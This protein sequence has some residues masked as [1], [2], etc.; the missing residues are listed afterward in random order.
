MRAFNSRRG[1]YSEKRRPPWLFLLIFAAALLTV[2]VIIGNLLPL[3]LNEAAYEALRQGTEEEEPP[4]I[5][6]TVKRLHAYA[7]T[8]GADL[9]DVWE[10]PHASVTLNAP[11]TRLS[12]TSAVASYLGYE[13]Y[14]STNLNDSMEELDEAASYISGIFYPYAPYLESEDLRDAEAARETALMREFLRAGGDEIL[15]R[16]LPFS[17]DGIELSDILNYVENVSTALGNTPV[18]VA[19]PLSV[20]GEK[21]SHRLLVRLSEVA[22]RLCLDLGAADGSLTPEGWLSECDYYLSQYQMRL[23]LSQSQTDLIAAAD[24]LN[25]VQTFT[26]IPDAQL[27]IP[28][29]K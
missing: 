2:T 13:S 20:L 11:S 28:E 17:Q 22:D 14:R 15:L 23:L 1:A 18:V 12:Y 4:Q 7:Y 24:N 19:V 3:L 6:S 26:R 9:D 29:P 27:G 21:N 5:Q 8:L 16:S 10:N 25:D